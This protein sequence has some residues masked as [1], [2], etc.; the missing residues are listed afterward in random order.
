MSVKKLATS[1]PSRAAIERH[2][3]RG[4]RF[5]FLKERLARI[6]V[7]GVWT[8]LEEG[9]V[10]GDGRRSPERIARALDECDG[11]L[12]RAGMILQAAIEELDE[13]D[14]HYRVAHSEWEAHARETL[15]RRKKEK[16]HSGVVTKD[17]VDDWIARHIED[18]R[19]WRKARRSLDRS[20]SLAKQMFAAWESRSASLRKQADLN[21]SRRGIDPKLL[22]RRDRR[23]RGEG[24]DDGEE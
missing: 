15:E 24:G 4:K 20:K 10:L 5:G 22:D 19:R 9:L 3:D 6:D 8:E 18:Y 17:L 13:F 2:E 16:R 23:R 12:R 14:L 1:E 7:E 11:N 21:M